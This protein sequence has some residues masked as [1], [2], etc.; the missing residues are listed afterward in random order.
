VG[1]A[2]PGVAGGAAAVH[3]GAVDG[4]DG[5]EAPGGPS[6]EIYGLSET[7]IEKGYRISSRRSGSYAPVGMAVTMSVRC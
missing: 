5:A 7:T 3:P 4:R 1:A 6:A 2:R